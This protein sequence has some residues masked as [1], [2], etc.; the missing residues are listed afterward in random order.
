MVNPHVGVLG[1]V[2]DHMYCARIY[3]VQKSLLGYLCA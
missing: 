3:A 2:K 1:G